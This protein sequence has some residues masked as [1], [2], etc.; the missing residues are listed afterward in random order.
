MDNDS[1]AVDYF[2]SQR[3]IFIGFFSKEELRSL[4]KSLNDFNF[5][6]ALLIIKENTLNR[7]KGD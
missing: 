4:E 6:K 1:E 2:N 3:D 7:D 5:D